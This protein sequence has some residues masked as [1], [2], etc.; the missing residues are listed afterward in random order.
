MHG[1]HP[2][3][4]NW[5]SSNKRMACVLCLEDKQTH[6]AQSIQDKGDQLDNRYL[7]N[8]IDYKSTYC[9]V[10]L[11]HTKDAAAKQFEAFLVLCEKLF[12][13]KIHVLRTNGGGRYASLYLVCK[14]TGVAH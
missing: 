2:A 6:N 8:I 13:V 1:A 10:F 12:G 9:R 11:A 5:L 7:V 4:C 14:R 3:L